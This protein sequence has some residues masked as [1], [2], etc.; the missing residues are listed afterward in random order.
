MP[1]ATL[2]GKNARTIVS[3]VTGAGPVGIH[4]EANLLPSLVIKNGGHASCALR[5]YE[6]HSSIFSSTKQ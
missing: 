5:D 1:L 2:A 4:K 3:A 6:F